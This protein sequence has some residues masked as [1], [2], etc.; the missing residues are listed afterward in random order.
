MNKKNYLC[1]VFAAFVSL[2][3]AQNTED[4]PYSKPVDGD[5]SYAFGVLM[6]ADLKQFGLDFDYDEFMNGFRAAMDGKSKISDDEALPIVQETVEQA[7]NE[8]AELNLEKG[9]R[10]LAENGKKTGIVTT[11]S[12]LQYE[13]LEKGEGE[14]PG[15]ESRVKVNYKGT[16]ING[17]EFDNS[18]KRGRPAEFSIDRVIAGW[19]EAIQLMPVGSHYKFF[20]PSDLAY[21]DQDM[22]NGVIPANSVLI[23]DV[24]LL[25]VL[26]K[27]EE[28]DY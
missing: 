11:K 28:N 6:G 10:F 5:T 15:P 19:T 25:E 20:I 4:T 23:F 12:G 26:D 21:G 1:V 14:L 7:V 3:Y 17:N 8:I 24:E 13:V 18:Y 2:V 9:K 22:G 27:D 16:L